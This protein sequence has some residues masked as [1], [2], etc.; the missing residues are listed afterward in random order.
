MPNGI[1][2]AKWKME[3]GICEVVVFNGPAQWSPRD[4]RKPLSNKSKAS[5]IPISNVWCISC[6]NINHGNMLMWRTME[7]FLASISAFIDENMYLD[8]DFTCTQGARW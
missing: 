6:N 4:N 7:L 1:C 8:E 2:D 5:S 3:Y